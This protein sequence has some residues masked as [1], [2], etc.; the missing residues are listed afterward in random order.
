MIWASNLGRAED[1]RSAPCKK[2]K[3]LERPQYG[4]ASQSRSSNQGKI[5]RNGQP[6]ILAE[7]ESADSFCTLFSS[8]L[9]EESFDSLFLSRGNPGL[10]GA[11]QGRIQIQGVLSSHVTRTVHGVD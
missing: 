1:A 11:P 6:R 10:P 9:D 8:K 4:G 3:K 7:T 2:K 5:K